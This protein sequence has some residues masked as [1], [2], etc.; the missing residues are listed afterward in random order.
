M[1]TPNR[2]HEQLYY[3]FLLLRTREL[4]QGRSSAP[5]LL[6]R[7]AARGAGEATEDRCSFILTLPRKNASPKQLSQMKICEGDIH[8]QPYTLRKLDAVY[9]GVCPA[10]SKFKKRHQGVGE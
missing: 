6:Q 4:L 7:L 8:T 5:R 3:P 10:A 9:P 2:S 1:E